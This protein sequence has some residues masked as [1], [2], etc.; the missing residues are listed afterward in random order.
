MPHTPHL[1]T[2]TSRLFRHLT[3]GTSLA[4]PGP[5]LMLNIFFEAPMQVVKKPLLPR[6]LFF[7]ITRNLTTGDPTWKLLIANEYLE[8]DHPLRKA[9]TL[10]VSNQSTCTQH[11]PLLQAAISGARY[12][13]LSEKERL[14]LKHS[15]TS[16]EPQKNTLPRPHKRSTLRHW[17]TSKSVTTHHRYCSGT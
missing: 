2:A 15:A 16:L 7:S 12:A 10:R 11:E 3:S 6:S 13:D 5:T 8:R 17:N 1:N 9:L 14:H 4:H